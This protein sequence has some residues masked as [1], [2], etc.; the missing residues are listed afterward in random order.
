MIKVGGTVASALDSRSV[1]RG[2]MPTRTKLRNNLGQVVYTSVPLSPSSITIPVAR[3][4][5]Y[6]SLIP[7]GKAADCLYIF[8]L[9]SAPGPTLGNEY[10]RTIP[11][12]MI[13]VSSMLSHDELHT[14]V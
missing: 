12:V 3:S 6:P 9:G 5:T 11:S 4:K 14:V 8:S 13:T 10:G 7:A 2:S 1:D